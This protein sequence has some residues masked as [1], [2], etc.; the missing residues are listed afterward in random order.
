MEKEVLDQMRIWL[1][2]GAII[3]AT[4]VNKSILE[5]G[6]DG[7]NGVWIGGLTLIFPE[8]DGVEEL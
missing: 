4:D 7:R 8:K 6:P 1:V 5:F 2:N 3:K